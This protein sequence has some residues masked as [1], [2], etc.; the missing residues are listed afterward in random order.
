WAVQHGNPETVDDWGAIP[1]AN[2][3]ITNTT[4]P[5]GYQFEFYQPWQKLLDAEM[6]TKTKIVVGQ[7]IGWFIFPNNSKEIGPSNQDVA[8]SPFKRTN[9]SGNPSVWATVVLE[10]F[11]AQPVTTPPATGGTPAAGQ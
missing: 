6:N 2:L 10:P 7:K 8:M 1:P 3:A 11:Q 4:K 5:V 9:P